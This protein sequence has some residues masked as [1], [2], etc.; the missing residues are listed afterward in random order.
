MPVHIQQVT[1]R[2][3]PGQF[4]AAAL[5][6]V[7]YRRDNVYIV[8]GC[9]NVQGNL[10]LCS[11]TLWHQMTLRRFD[12]CQIRESMDIAVQVPQN[13]MLPLLSVSCYQLFILPALRL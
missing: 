7:L 13:I 3:K 11:L 9:F 8:A 12:I 5:V 4:V 1:T 6:I 2:T 10:E